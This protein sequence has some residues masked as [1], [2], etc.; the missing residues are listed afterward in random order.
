MSDNMPCIEIVRICTDCGRPVPKDQCINCGSLRI[1]EPKVCGGYLHRCR[2]YKK[3]RNIF[4]YE[5]F[6]C[7]KCGF[8][9]YRK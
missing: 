4:G 8:K 2:G 7:K 1:S 6:Q 3:G 9:Y 5:V